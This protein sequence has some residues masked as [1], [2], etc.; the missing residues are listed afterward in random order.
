MQQIHTYRINSLC[1]NWYHVCC[2]CSLLSVSLLSQGGEVELLMEWLDGRRFKVL[3]V[4][5]TAELVEE[6]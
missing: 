5:L 4:R 2:V 3:R 1:N 6:G